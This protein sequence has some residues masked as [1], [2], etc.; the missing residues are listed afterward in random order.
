MSRQS[1]KLFCNHLH[2]DIKFRL[3]DENI[4]YPAHKEVVGNAS[5]VLH[6]MI[7]GNGASLPSSIIV[8]PN[9]SSD[10]FLSVLK[11]VYTGNVKWHVDNY[12]DILEIGKYFGLN[13]LE[14]SYKTYI[15]NK[16]NFGNALDMYAE[17][18]LVNNYICR[19]AM[20]IIQLQFHKI[21]K[22]KDKTFQFFDLPTQAVTQILQMDELS[23]KN[24]RDILDKITIWATSEDIGD[25]AS[26]SV[27]ADKSRPIRLRRTNLGGNRIHEEL[28]TRWRIE[29]V[30]GIANFNLN[31]LRLEDEDDLEHNTEIIHITSVDKTIRIHGISI[32][33]TKEIYV[34]KRDH[35]EAIP[36]YYSKD[37]FYD[38]MFEAAIEISTNTTVQIKVPASSQRFDIGNDLCLLRSE[39][40]E[41]AG[42]NDVPIAAIFISILS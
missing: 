30:N 11:F 35:F 27:L 21:L 17:Y 36:C 40:M 8:V 10:A 29:A 28:G 33:S 19:T 39:N 34:K 18:F 1:A 14:I 22:L 25:R 4:E 26:T 12:V 16:I 9:C 31:M 23:I 24:E 41:K 42:K 2:S 15:A 13:N 5:D 38:L 3:E 6:N 20:K 7:Y 37:T 32:L